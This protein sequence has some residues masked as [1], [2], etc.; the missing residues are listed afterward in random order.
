MTVIAKVIDSP[1]P[2]LDQ[3][4]RFAPQSEIKR[5]RRI[6]RCSPRAIAAPECCDLVQRRMPWNAAEKKEGSGSAIAAQRIIRSQFGAA[7]FRA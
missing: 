1:R 7:K 5:Q 4:G 3:R 6:L 2:S